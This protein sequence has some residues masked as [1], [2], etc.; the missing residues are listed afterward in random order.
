LNQ[1]K[2]SQGELIIEEK[3]VFKIPS[4]SKAPFLFV[5]DNNMGSTFGEL[6]RTPHSS[7]PQQERNEMRSSSSAQHREH[8]KPCRIDIEFDTSK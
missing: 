3:Q 5:N 7:I 8:R 6:H 4:K 1:N 2:R